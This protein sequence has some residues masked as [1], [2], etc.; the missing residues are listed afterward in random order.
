MAK[1]IINNQEAVSNHSIALSMKSLL[2]IV[3][4]AI[5]ATAFVVAGVVYAFTAPKTP[6][7]LQA[8]VAP[9]TTH[10]QPNDIDISSIDIDEGAKGIAIGDIGST[11]NPFIQALEDLNGFKVDDSI[12]PNNTVYIMYDPRCPYC[13]NIYE[14]TKADDLKAKGI[15]VKWLPTTALGVSSTHD[16]VV[17]NATYAMQAKNLN[18]FDGVFNGGSSAPNGFVPNDEQLE[19]LNNN[20]EFLRASANQVYGE[21]APLSVPA[22]MF[23]DKRLNEPRLIFGGGREQYELIFGE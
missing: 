10:Q 2:A 13:H 21:N 11:T 19:S 9:T 15:T 22:M 12:A 5:I 16:D 23:I 8:Q 20:L 17:L 7:A 4:G 3:F 1:Q 18:E 6:P 14:M